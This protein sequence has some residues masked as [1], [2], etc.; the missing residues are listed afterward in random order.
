M[1]PTINQR[2]FMKW[3]PKLLLTA[4]D[5]LTFRY[6]FNYK[7]MTVEQ[8][9]RYPFKKETDI[10]NVRKRLRKFESEG[11]VK[12]QAT[13]FQGKIQ[14]YFSI[15]KKALTILKENEGLE[16]QR[17]QLESNS[18]IHDLVLVEIGE[19]LKRTNNCLFYY[20]ENELQC[21]FGDNFGLPDVIENNSDAFLKL[22]LGDQ[23]F[24]VVIEYENSAASKNKYR[25]LVH[26]YYYPDYINAVFFFYQ[27]EWIKKTIIEEE[28]KEYPNRNPKFFF[29]K[30]NSDKI[31][32][33]NLTLKDR[34][35]YELE[36]K[37]K[38]IA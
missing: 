12:V 18:V 3:P 8:I 24:N 9:W 33:E 20:T 5:M 16:L 25:E 37:R 10:G 14:R 11:L 1:S 2:R 21:I 32:L 38:K 22:K 4:R 13:I 31:D 29:F 26:N 19:C 6:L 34:G 15:T 35:G 36:L 30:L 28:E 27:K 17:K 7:V 23:R